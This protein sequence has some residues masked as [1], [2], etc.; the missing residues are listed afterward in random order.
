M[1]RA[2]RVQVRESG[3]RV[4]QAEDCVTTRLGLLEILPPE[5]MADLLEKELL[6][7][8]FRK[9]GDVLRR[10]GDGVTTTVDPKS[11]SVHVTSQSEKRV[12]VEATREGIAFDDVGPNKKNVKDKL[13]QQAKDD[14]ERQ[15][16]HQQGKLQQQATERLERSLID[17][18]PELDRAVNKVTAEALKRKAAQ[19]GHVK[20]ITED[21]ATGSLTIKIEV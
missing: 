16:A 12:K 9:D 17:L 18:K 1:S 4:V 3:I 5:E 20:E 14:L 21:Q 8:G 13:T 2:Y 10:D 11:A 6:E 15:A 7:R 19:L